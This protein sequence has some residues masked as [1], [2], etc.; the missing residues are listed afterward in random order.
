MVDKGCEV[1]LE[2]DE[3]TSEV[4]STTHYLVRLHLVRLYRGYIPLYNS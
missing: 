1:T 3:V 2:F 4:D